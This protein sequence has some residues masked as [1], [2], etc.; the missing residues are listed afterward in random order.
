MLMCYFLEG[1]AN[2]EVIVLGDF[3]DFDAHTPD[4][5]DNKPRSRVL[6]ILTTDLGLSSVLDSVP[7]VRRMRSLSAVG[8]EHLAFTQPNEG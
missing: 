5:L 2:N 7:K 4:A 1:Y 6:Q 3:N 8:I